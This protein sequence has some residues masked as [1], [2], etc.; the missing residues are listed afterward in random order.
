MRQ[1]LLGLL[2]PAAG[3][4]QVEVHGEGQQ[5]RGGRRG[6]EVRDAVDRTEDPIQTCVAVDPVSD[7]RPAAEQRD[8]A[9]DVDHQ[10]RPVYPR[11]GG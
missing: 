3:P 7:A 4:D 6:E 5:V 10:Q 8:H 11:A 2:L 1:V 9:V